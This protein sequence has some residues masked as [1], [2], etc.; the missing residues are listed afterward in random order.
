MRVWLGLLSLLVALWLVV[1]L[2]QRQTA[3]VVPA[4]SAAP[5]GRGPQQIPQQFQQALDQALQQNQ[6]K[7]NDATDPGR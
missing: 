3:T 6:R 2:V 1:T 7:L 5:E 4:P